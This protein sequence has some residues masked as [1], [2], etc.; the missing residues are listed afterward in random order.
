M[1]KRVRKK[2]KEIKKTLMKRRHLPVAEQGRWLQSVVRGYF[3]YFAVPET[4]EILSAFRKHVSRLWLRAL[5]HRSQKKGGRLTW[6]RMERLIDSWIPKMKI[7]HP[8]PDE[9]LTV[10]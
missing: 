6:K 8:Y 9:R 7:V 3:A 5:R 1:A 4:S 10:R 2:L